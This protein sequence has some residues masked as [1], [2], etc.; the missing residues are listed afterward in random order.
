MTAPL[1]YE[2]HLD[3]AETVRAGREVQRRQRL[4]WIEWAVWPMLAI[5]TAFYLI[6]GTPWQDLWLLGLVAAFFLCLRWLAPRIQRWQLRRA[7]SETP[8]LR[9]PQVYQFTDAG[10]TIRGGAA[11]TTLGWDS[12]VKADETREFFLLF[13]SKRCAYYLPKRV[14]GDE[15]ERNALRA[16]L[17]AKLGARA[18][19][20]RA[21][22]LRVAPA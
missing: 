15:G 17:R 22:E 14:A 9:G 8:S 3:P 18:A 10:L 16:L 2:F 7:Y 6:S 12:F 13:Y 19:G 21:D 4:A 20:L 5:L 11:S 1:T